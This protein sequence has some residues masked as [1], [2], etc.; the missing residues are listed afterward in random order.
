MS[1]MR[2]YMNPETTL[3]LIA[4]LHS[5]RCLWDNKCKEFQRKDIKRQELQN[6]ADHFNTTPNEIIRRIKSLKTQFKRQHNKIKKSMNNPRTNRPRRSTWFGY[7][8]MTFLL[9]N[10]EPYSSIQVL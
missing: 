4:R 5:T 8:N 2:T 3:E 6:L 9:E 1:G 10:D 7:D